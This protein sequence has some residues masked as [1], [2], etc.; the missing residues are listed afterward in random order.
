M[1]DD[2]KRFV[3]WM[4]AAI[5]TGLVFSL[6]PSWTAWWTSAGLL[7]LV[8]LALHAVLR[9]PVVWIEGVDVWDK[10][11]TV[12]IWTVALV[13]ALGF[14]LI[15]PNASWGTRIVALLACM[16]IAAAFVTLCERIRDWWL[17]Y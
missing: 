12:V 16:I 7:L 3:A 2:S 6:Y 14:M 9:V 17:G 11:A 10:I 4:G 5:I 15:F 8:G 13:G 1:S